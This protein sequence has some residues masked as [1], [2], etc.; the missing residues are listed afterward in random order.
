MNLKSDCLLSVQKAVDR[1]RRGNV[2]AVPT[3]TV[4]GLAC[5]INIP[6]A[7]NMVYQIKNRPAQHP[8]IIHIANF[9][10]LMA[11]AQE[12]PAYVSFL[13][14]HFWPGPLTLILRK[15]SNVPDLIT[16]YQDS[17]AVRMPNQPL[18][19]QIIRELGVPIA[20]PSANKFAGISPTT[21]AHVRSE[22]GGLVDVVDGGKCEHGIESTILDVRDEN[23]CTILRHGPISKE[24]LDKFFIH[25]QLN[26]KVVNGSSDG[27]R[28]PGQHKKHYAP[29]KPLISFKSND[30]LSTLLSK[31][32]RSFIIHYSE[33]NNNQPH[34]R[35][36][37]NPL[38]FA[39]E[40]YNS[41]RIAD[42]VDCQTILIER[43]PNEVGW[44]AVNDR[45]NR[46][47]TFNYER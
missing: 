28:V 16:G 38:D 12:I 14:E 1:L 7:I 17:V 6:S 20:A 31:Y 41:L 25:H 40:I 33:I 27:V 19:L 42:T 47:V 45:L 2:I 8:L 35:L 13:I 44:D 3:E 43:P 26:V 11:Y 5:A 29:Q 30:D 21:A 36:K 15:R 37:D 39:K 46:A 22:F 24:L 4:Y 23:F 18:L 10:D 9:N 32:P 34:Y